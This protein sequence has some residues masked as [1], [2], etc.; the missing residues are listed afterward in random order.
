MP[1]LDSIATIPIDGMNVPEAFA[2]LER[3][4]ANL[5]WRRDR[6]TRELFSRIDP[7]LWSRG[8]TPVTI[9]RQSRAIA[10]AAR[11]K[12]FV[13]Q[14]RSAVSR[15]DR[16]ME[17][18][19]KASHPRFEQGPIA[20][21]CAEFGLQ[22]RVPLYCGGLGILA[23]DHL[24][25]ASDMGLPFVAV[26]LFYR[27]GFF[28]QVLDRDG[29]QQH[30]DPVVDPEPNSLRRVLCPESKEP[31][32]IRVA[33]PG[34]VVSA[35]VWLVP[36]GK[37]PLL[38]LDTDL[39]ENAPEDRIITSQLYT[40]GRET[41]VCQEMVLGAG[42]VRALSALGISPSVFH[43][44]E[45]HSAFLLLER[46]RVACKEGLGWQEAVERIRSSSVLTIHTPVPEG[47][48]RFDAR[49]IGSFVGSVAPDLPVDTM[50]KLGLDSKSDPC[51]FDMTAFAL[52]LTHAANGVSLLH[53]RT[54]DATWHKV[55][56][57]RLIGVTN[58]VHMPTW[59]GPEIRALLEGAGAC[60]D[61]VIDLKVEAGR[62]GRGRWPAVHQIGDAAL[63][64]AHEAQKW[65]LM[66]F[67][68][69]RLR[70]QHS[71]YGMSPS[72]LREFDS[73]LDPGTLIIGF[74]RRFATYKRA[75]L[76]FSDQKRLLRLLNDPNRPVRIVFSGKAYPTDRQG[77]AVLAKLYRFSRSP[78][79][80]GKVFVL[81]D[82]DMEVA[83]KLVQG[84][85]LWLNNPR[86]PMEASGTSGMKAAANGV[87]NASIMDGWWD[88]AYEGGSESNGFSI[89]SRKQPADPALQDAADASD[90]YT[91]LEDQ[92]VP[93]YF[94]RDANG[95]PREWLKIMKN[96]IAD[97]LQAFSTR[98][99]IEDYIDKMY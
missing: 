27:R 89:G 44:N 36:V 12:A 54:A 3:L 13:D 83:E 31:L 40:V 15:F 34:R 45:G 18:S 2:G 63:R 22:S 73:V 99:M 37:V 90:L 59:I 68:R 26:G 29:R 61:P 91:V 1:V 24:M 95:I 70:T 64:G 9:L 11:D 42:G 88:E 82:Y 71:R 5:Y 87:P 66:E 78:R 72:E 32:V 52:R 48:E 60:F 92:V 4:A 56:G 43:L 76:I 62:N 47:N 93:A 25:E 65:R 41:R 86:R 50:L 84:A 77:Q 85:D 67:V 30:F 8:A 97:S 14:A 49:L 10:S 38:L 55:A 75:G 51:V 33:M 21:F 58:G 57:R 39:Q 69:D 28:K 46:L 74:S 35:A 16:Y 6:E 53:G 94:K 81:E 96:S 79:F 19:A 20:Y 7:Q 17:E 23:G 80:R 98:R